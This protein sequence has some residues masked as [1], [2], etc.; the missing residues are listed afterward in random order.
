MILLNCEVLYHNIPEIFI[1]K[2]EQLII[3]Y[4]KIGDV[5]YGANKKQYIMNFTRKTIITKIEKIEK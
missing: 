1:C 2:M 5:M 3:D 4:I